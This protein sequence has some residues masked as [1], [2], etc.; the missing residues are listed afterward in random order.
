MLDIEMFEHNFSR[1]HV[2]K[3][4]TQQDAKTLEDHVTQLELEITSQ[5][6]KLV[7]LQAALQE[8]TT[9]RNHRKEYDA[10]TASILQ[11]P[12]RKEQEKQQHDLQEQLFKLE[13]EHKRVS[14]LIEQR[15]KE[16]Q[17]LFHA[18]QSLSVSLT[19]NNTTTTS[20]VA[21]EE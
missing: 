4:T 15:N 14:D 7:E 18:I 1:Y 12:D 3:N 10:I 19:S 8:E 13:Q 2:L 20:N 6:K 5:K 9:L 16:F 17:M 11:L 21:M